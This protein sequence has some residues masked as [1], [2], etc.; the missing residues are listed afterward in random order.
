MSK[1]ALS[2]QCWARECWCV[3]IYT[4]QGQGGGGACDNLPNLPNLTS[5]PQSRTAMYQTNI[6]NE[7]V[8]TN[9]HQLG[10]VYL[11]FV[12]ILTIVSPRHSVR[13]NNNDMHNA[14]RTWSLDIF[15]IIYNE[16]WL[17]STY[18]DRTEFHWISVST[19]YRK[20]IKSIKEAILY[21]G[22]LM[23]RRIYK[24]CFSGEFGSCGN[25]LT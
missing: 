23:S 19:Y 5:V 13:E 12:F 2:S 7:V 22:T 3:T 8:S 20:L 18:N 24:V 14:N 21:N 16:S 17:K 25:C 4:R 1:W 10:W 9:D 11:L 15:F 6:S